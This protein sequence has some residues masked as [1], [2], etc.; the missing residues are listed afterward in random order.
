M[1]VFATLLSSVMNGSPFQYP[2]VTI[3]AGDHR[4]RSGHVRVV[5][6]VALVFL[7]GGMFE[8]PCGFVLVAGP[9]LLDGPRLQQ[10]G[11]I[12][13]VGIVA[14][15]AI[16]LNPQVAV[17]PVPPVGMTVDAQSR[18][19]FLKKAFK[20]RRVGVMAGKTFPFLE[21]GVGQAFPTGRVLVAS[22]AKGWNGFQGLS[23]AVRKMEFV[24][25][26]TIPVCD[27]LMDEFVLEEYLMAVLRLSDQCSEQYRKGDGNHQ[28]VKS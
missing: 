14:L 13:C 21:G 8:L 3:L 5:A 18:C 2:G 4:F 17:P 20:A 24:A 9:A 15:K 22:E 19:F 25:H 23:R 7:K 16:S 26:R 1:A 11:G 6:L 12:R 10:T 28:D 27:R